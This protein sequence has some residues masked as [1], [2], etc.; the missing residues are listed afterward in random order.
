MYS[1]LSAV[2]FPVVAVLLVGT[3]IW[4]YQEHQEKNSILIKAENQYQRAFHNLSYHLDHLHRELGNAL[5]VHSASR[6]FQRKSLIN[7]WRVTNEAKSEIDQLPLTLMPFHK[8]EKFLASIS[9]FTYHVAIRDM[10]KSP[11]TDDEM[12]KLQALYKRSKEVANEV[13]GV[14]TKVLSHNLRWMDVE[15]AIASERE[16]NDNMII[17]GFKLV[18]KRVSEYSE[19]DFGPSAPNIFETKSYKHLQGK[20]VTPE[21]VKRKAKSFFRL[22]DG[23]TLRVVENG[24]GTEYSSYSVTVPSESERSLRADFTKRGGKL[25]WFTDNRPVAAKN[26]SIGEA[27]ELARQFLK[28]HEF[29]DMVPIQYDEYDKTASLIMARQ[30]NGVIVYPEKLTV[31]VA[32]DNGDVIGVHASELLHAK[33]NRNVEEPKLTVE[34][35]KKKLNPQ[36]KA[37]K[38]TLAIIEND[39]R[40]EVLCY[41]FQGKINGG[42]YRIYINAESGQEEKVEQL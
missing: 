20:M 23:Q 6:D 7:V 29:G 26:V 3:A 15:T 2:L 18:D 28:R 30:L 24:H 36:F 1:R 37:N 31:K 16:K 41:E 5:A 34:E 21:D 4:G 8:T 11:I 27:S 13:R 12:K 9:N 38:H 32:L 33:D 14:Q 22:E 42:Q 39:M 10:T 35:A 17:D 25:I 40:K 19:V